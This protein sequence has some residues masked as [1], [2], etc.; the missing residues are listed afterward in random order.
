MPGDGTRKKLRRVGWTGPLIELLP[1]VAA[2]VY[3]L[4]AGILEPLYIAAAAGWLIVVLGQVLI[5]RMGRIIVDGDTIRH[6][7]P[8]G[9]LGELTGLD[10]ELPLEGLRCELLIGDGGLAWFRP[11]QVHAILIAPGHEPRTLE[12]LLDWT[13][14]HVPTDPLNRSRL[15]EKVRESDEDTLSALRQYPLVQVLEERDVRVEMATADHLAEA[16][17]ESR[18]AERRQRRERAREQVERGEQARDE[19]PAK[20]H[21][22]DARRYRAR[23]GH[24]PVAQRPQPHWRPRSPMERHR[25]ARKDAR[26][27]LSAHVAPVVLMILM[28]LAA[29]Y[30][31]VDSLMFLE[32]GLASWHGLVWLPVAGA[33]VIL[34]LAALVLRSGYDRASALGLVALSWIVLSVCTYPLV[35][36]YAQAVGE[37]PQM[38]DYILKEPGV[39]EPDEPGWPSVYRFRRHHEYWESIPE[40]TTYPLEMRRAPGDIYLVNVDRVYASKAD[41]RRRQGGSL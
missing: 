3:L 31:I 18:K 21:R 12:R 34:P 11:W 36:R 23:A 35:I 20:Q 16:L 30:A 40:G 41:Y 29:V 33:L 7:T 1:P 24:S 13:R 19:H 6:E 8:L 9:R 26:H 22:T 15:S 37:A 4:W 5:S 39:L 27:D 14:T 28:A 10:W 25:P 2:L 17:E 32:E 38:V